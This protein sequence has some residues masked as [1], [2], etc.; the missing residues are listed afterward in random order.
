MSVQSPFKVSEIQVDNIIYK[1]IKESTNRKIIFIKYK[2]NKKYKNL[3]FQLPTLINNSSIESKDIEIILEC[4]DNKKK[5]KLINFLN[6]LDKKIIKDA[7]VNAS[8]WF[9]HIEDKTSVNYN[10]IIRNFQDNE[11]IKFKILNEKE[12][13]TNLFID[14]DIKIDIDDIPTDGELKCILELYAIWINGN[15]FG[16]I[17]R[18]VIL[19][20]LPEP[21]T[22]YNYKI[23]NET[24]VAPHYDSDYDSESDSESNTKQNTKHNTKHNT[25]YNNTSSDNKNNNTNNKHEIFTNNKHDSSVNNSNS[26]N[27]NSIISDIQ[28]NSDTESDQPILN[29]INSNS[30]PSTIFL[31][32]IS[33]IKTNCS[34]TSSELNEKSF[35]RLILN[36]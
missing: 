31:K 14:D 9:D 3:V 10:H 6:E 12:F 16:P 26:K 25:N 35:T 33:E 17:L 36:T 24:E 19:S 15:N 21:D 28:S 13:K 11:S 8:V 4:K 1:N 5:D 29:F 22:E 34:S 20:F 2:D 30:D 18:P 32:N 23:L 27:I 7:K